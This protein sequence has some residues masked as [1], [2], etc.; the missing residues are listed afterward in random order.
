MPAPTNH[1]VRGRSGFQHAGVSQNM[2]NSIGGP[3]G[4]VKIKARIIGNLIT[5]VNNVSKHGEHQFLNATNHFAI[6]KCP[7]RRIAK[8]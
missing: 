7:S 4:G 2:K 3:I 8:F 6:D 5:D 1:N